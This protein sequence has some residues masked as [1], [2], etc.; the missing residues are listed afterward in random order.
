MKR[1]AIIVCLAALSFTLAFAQEGQGTSV[2]SD[3]ALGDLFTVAPELEF[4]VY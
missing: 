3:F 1:A 4:G 2:Q